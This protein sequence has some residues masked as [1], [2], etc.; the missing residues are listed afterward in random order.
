M[1]YLK[2][3]KDI[4]KKET[5]SVKKFL[6]TFLK[7][8]NE[9]GR[10]FDRAI[11]N[12]ANQFYKEYLSNSLIE[13]HKFYFERIIN[14]LRI[15]KYNYDPKKVDTLLK[16]LENE[17]HDNFLQITATFSK[18]KLEDHEIFEKLTYERFFS[19]ILNYTMHQKIQARLEN[20][21]PHLTDAI[22]LFYE[23]NDFNNFSNNL[24]IDDSEKVTILKI[25]DIFKKH[26]KKYILTKQ[27]NKPNNENELIDIIKST[28]DENEKI[29]LLNL[30]LFHGDK[31]DGTDKIKLFLLIGELTDYSI[32]EGLAKN[33]TFYKKVAA[34]INHYGIKSQRQYCDTILNKIESLELKTTKDQLR[35]LKSSTITMK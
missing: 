9:N 30:I 35:S 12:L 11:A 17:V 15:H 13:K 28:F 19:E 31:I 34:G 18:N 7:K 2:D 21:I 14:D 22:K 24:L 32:F 10:N 4:I 5:N 29:I 3:Y 25:R 27:T 20:S 33:S 1:E 26:E 8:E 6:V 16:T 23:L